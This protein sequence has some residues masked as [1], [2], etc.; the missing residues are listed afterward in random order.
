MEAFTKE[1]HIFISEK[2]SCKTIL[3]QTTYPHYSI[4]TFFITL[5]MKKNTPSPWYNFTIIDISEGYQEI[6]Y[7][8]IIPKFPN[9]HIV[10]DTPEQLAEVVPIMIQEEIEERRKEGLSIP[11]PDNIPNQYSGKFTFRTSPSVH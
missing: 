4:R 1:N 9:I 8:A 2:K 11:K 5:P 3:R 7:K 6:G 10:G